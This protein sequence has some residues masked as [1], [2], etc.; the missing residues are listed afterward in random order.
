MDQATLELAFKEWW[1]ASY[2]R[3]PLSHSIM[4]HVAFAA[5][6]LEL[7]KANGK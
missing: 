3:L 7:M 1:E 2:G 4:T 6:I 5:H